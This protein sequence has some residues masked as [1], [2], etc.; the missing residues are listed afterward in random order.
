MVQVYMFPIKK[1]FAF[2][3]YLL[4]SKLKKITKVYT[5]HFL[6]LNLKYCYVIHMMALHTFLSL[7]FPCFVRNHYKH[8]NVIITAT[9]FVY[10]VST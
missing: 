5:M 4:L 6:F 10:P 9:T 8:D 7:V 1:C 2:L 3:K